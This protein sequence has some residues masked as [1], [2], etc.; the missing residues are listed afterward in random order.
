MST[1]DH[2]DLRRAS[3]G[4]R[5]KKARRAGSR[6]S[7]GPPAEPSESEQDMMNFTGSVKGRT[8]A[9]TAAAVFAIGAVVFAFAAGASA[10]EPPDE[11]QRHVAGTNEI[12]SAIDQRLDQAEADR[13]VIQDLLQR[14]DVRALAANAGLD[15]ERAS[16]AAATLSGSSLESLAAQARAVDTDVAGGDNRVIISTTGIIIILLV[17]ILLL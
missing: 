15:I 12:Q 14:E 8:F 10:A 1:L 5:G 13:Q 3:S 9:S 2:I 6:R 11:P 17:L 7:A 4:R 16:A